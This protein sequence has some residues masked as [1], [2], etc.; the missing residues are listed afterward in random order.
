MGSVL[1]GVAEDDVGDIP[2]ILMEEEGEA[3]ADVDPACVDEDITAAFDELIEFMLDIDMPVKLLLMIGL[4][5]GLFPPIGVPVAVYVDI[6]LADNE[7]ELIEE[8]AGECV[9]D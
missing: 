3:I 4:S 8:I 9:E 1:D 6:G 7:C 5:P 2:G